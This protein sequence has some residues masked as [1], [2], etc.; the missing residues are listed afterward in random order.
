MRTGP[1]GRDT[2]ATM[3]PRLLRA[4]NLTPPTRT[5]WGGE[6]IIGHY[7]AGLG[8]TG[9][10]V[11][12]ESWEVSVEPSFP[13]R[14]ADDDTL[15]ADAIAA[16]TALVSRGPC[17]AAVRTSAGNSIGSRPTPPSRQPPSAPPTTRRSPAHIPPDPYDHRPKLLGVK[18]S[19]SD[20]LTPPSHQSGPTLAEWP[21]PTNDTTF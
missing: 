14:F 4:D 7:K 16:T 15:L 6:R 5:P 3:R 9:V 21:A 8:I 2:A 1:S 19:V 11:V 18:T 13:S 10:Q 20:P 17:P 12:G